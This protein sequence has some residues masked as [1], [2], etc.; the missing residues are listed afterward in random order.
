MASWASYLPF[1]HPTRGAHGRPA[2]SHLAPGLAPWSPAPSQTVSRAREGRA[3]FR[4]VP[5]LPSHAWRAI[6]AQW[7]SWLLKGAD[8]FRQVVFQDP[9][10]VSFTDDLF[11]ITGIAVGI[12]NVDS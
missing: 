5:P 9:F 12:L 1:H 4:R 6:W 8:I 10:I 2:G 7:S 3:V 11:P